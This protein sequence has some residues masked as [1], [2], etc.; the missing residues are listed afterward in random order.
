MGTNGSTTRHTVPCWLALLAWL[1]GVVSM[2]EAASRAQPYGLRAALFVAE[3]FLALP[4]LVALRL[5]GIPL[6]RGLAL[7]PPTPLGWLLSVLVGGALWVGSVGLLELQY[8]V[9]APPPGFVEGFE[10]LHRTLRPTGPLDAV[11]SIA[12]IA[13]APAVCEEVLFRGLLLPALARPLRTWGAIVL[14][15]LL[16]AIIHI[17]RAGD[18]YTLYRVPFTL[19]VA[20]ALGFVRVR[21][22]SLLPGLV[23]HAVLNTITFSVVLFGAADTVE[24][25]NVPQ[26]AVLLLGGLVATAV[27]L[28][29]FP[30]PPDAV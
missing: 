16:F 17:D 25:A 18:A 20:L 24:T 26:G 27:L 23:A 3:A 12:A 6:A 30:R 2:G 22:G 5:W 28:R 7:G 21:A 8:G 11:V 29:W 13:L 14:S 4:A 9:W 1:V 19:A 15:A 10:A